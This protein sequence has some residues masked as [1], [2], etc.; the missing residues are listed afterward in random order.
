M[1]H[2]V[3]GM[4][5]T[6]HFLYADDEK[7]CLKYWQYWEKTNWTVPKF[8]IVEKIGNAP[9][10]IADVMI[11]LAWQFHK[12]HFFKKPDVVIVDTDEAA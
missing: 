10:T 5:E 9:L 4:S 2:E 3:R 7:Y 1:S 6:C 8:A 12:P 11:V